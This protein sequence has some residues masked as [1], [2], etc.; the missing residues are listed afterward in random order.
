MDGSYVMDGSIF[1]GG[2]IFK[3]GP[4][5]KGGQYLWTVKIMGGSRVNGAAHI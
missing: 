5:F 4:I 1:N 2:S 3:D